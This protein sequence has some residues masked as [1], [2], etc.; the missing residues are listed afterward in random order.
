MLCVCLFSLLFQ[1][2]ISCHFAYVKYS[3]YENESKYITEGTNWLQE[4]V[5]VTIIQGVAKKV[6]WL[7]AFFYELTS[8]NHS[9]TWIILYCYNGNSIP[10]N[11]HFWGEE[12]L[13]TGTFSF[14]ILIVPFLRRPCFFNFPDLDFTLFCWGLVSVSF[15]IL[16]FEE[17]LFFL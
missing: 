2:T 5:E 15:L 4:K 11:Y 7:I 16:I 1:S 6:S 10:S 8:A 12:I 9:L 13:N 14:L 3:H 17:G